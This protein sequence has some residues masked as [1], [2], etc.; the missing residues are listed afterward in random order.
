M[1]HF[2]FNTFFVAIDH[3]E[4][5]VM[6]KSPSDGRSRTSR[7]AAATSSS[8][9]LHS[10]VPSAKPVQ[11][12]SSSSRRQ[13][14]DSL[15]DRT[16]IRTVNRVMKPLA[17]RTSSG[18]SSAGSGTPNA[19]SLRRS[20][21]Q[22]DATSIRPRSVHI[23]PT[24]LSGV[25]A[26]SNLSGSTKSLNVSPN[27]K[28]LRD[29]PKAFAGSASTT[30]HSR[31]LHCQEPANSPRMVAAQ[32]NCHSQTP[33]EE[34]K[35]PGKESFISSPRQGNSRSI[36]GAGAHRSVARSDS[37]RVSRTKEDDARKMTER[38]GILHPSTSNSGSRKLSKENVVTNPSAEPPDVMGG[39]KKASST[40]AL[41]KSPKKDSA[42]SHYVQN[43]KALSG[44]QRNI[45][46]NS[47][48]RRI[49]TPNKCE[50]SHHMAVSRQASDHVLLKSGA[51]GSRL[52]SP[53]VQA[54]AEALPSNPVSLTRFT[55]HT[56]RAA[57]QPPNA[58]LD[59]SGA[60][61]QPNTFCT[62]TLP[63]SEIDKANKDIQ[64]K[65]Y[66][67]DF[68]VRD[69]FMDEFCSLRI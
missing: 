60:S 4:R 63:K 57:V 68:K 42:T 49:V 51:S 37:G 45:Q 55:P 11:T 14:G 69:H 28:T 13:S 35:N 23:A 44:A 24:T 10:N 66:S 12:A 27:V 32:T 3:D 7:S 40:T 20:S 43:P 53:M 25:E 26:V 67:S 29:K 19:V 62:L 18:A 52:V 41:N 22:R 39:M 46:N 15:L 33:R 34:Q 47:A 65:I 61:S 1:F 58:V 31:P 54:R 30:H 17:I 38:N 59:I 21:Q 9:R 5:T 36:K 64:H 48:T 16:D 8:A 50:T 2:W 6:V 56:S